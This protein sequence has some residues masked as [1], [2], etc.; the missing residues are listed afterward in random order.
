MRL[1]H[2]NPDSEQRKGD[3]QMKKYQAPELF[4]DEFAADTMIAS[5]NPKNG[6]AGN[7]QNC[8]GCKSTFGE[9]DPGNPENSCL[10]LPNTP[11]YSEYC[12]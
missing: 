10:Y 11:S 3:V 1:R 9:V 7:N 6:N 8:W 4:T 12:A 5:G 2:N